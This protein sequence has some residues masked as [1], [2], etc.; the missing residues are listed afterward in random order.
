M[1][2][3]AL[4]A[5]SEFLGAIAVVVSLIYVAA[6]IRQNS[7]ETKLLR[8]QSLISANTQVNV[9]MADNA[10]LAHITQEG[11]LDYNG[12]SVD[13]QWRF[14]C[15]VFFV[16]NQYDFAYH[17]FVGGQLE[18]TF[19]KRMDYELPL[20]LGLPGGREWW[21]KDKPRLSKEFAEYLDTRIAE[22]PRPDVLPTFGT[23]QD[24]DPI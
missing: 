6:Q 19:W 16:L 17:Q 7:R 1:N 8:T 11:F 10:E 12:L 5:I 23:R 20:F 21:E 18:E 2:W 9:L 22:F 24:N 4:G 3:E 15:L 13:E 14:G